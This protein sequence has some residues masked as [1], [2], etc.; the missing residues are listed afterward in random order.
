MPEFHPE[1]L[2]DAYRRI[3]EDTRHAAGVGFE[4]TCYYDR[5]G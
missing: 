1:I 2:P 4:G 5:D 3:C